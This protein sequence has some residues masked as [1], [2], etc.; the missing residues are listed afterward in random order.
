MPAGRLPSARVMVTALPK[1]AN[2]SGENTLTMRVSLIAVAVL[3]SQP[4]AL[5]PQTATDI[6][7]YEMAGGLSSLA[8][9]KPRPMATAP[10]Y[11]NQPF[12]D[13]GGQR[14]L[15]TANRDGK[16]TDI[17]EF[18][19]ASGRI[20]QLT[21]TGEG[22]YSPT[23]PT[24]RPTAP[25]L[26][27]DGFTVVRV[28]PDGTQRLWQFDRTGENPLLVLADVKPVG[29]HVWIDGD[30]LALYILG[31]PSTLQV[32][33][34]SGGTPEAVARDVGRTLRLVPGSS[35]VTFVQREA[36]GQ[37]AIRSLD[38]SSGR[39]ETITRT[40]EG[41]FDRDY[42]WLPDGRTILMSAGTKVLAWTRGETGWREVLDVARDGL[43][44]VTRMAVSPRAD[45]L[46]VVTTERQP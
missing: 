3:L 6:H 36:E 22:E 43:G 38:P 46:A 40:V 21:R 23:I 13:A 35:L 25:G 15:F 20:Q 12:F 44:A 8:R 27:R 32:A 24:I 28:E 19:R 31:N 9:A 41:S 2:D 26:A 17:Y 30:R 18:D 4:A 10:G 42:E 39:T 11:E 7:L 5:R 37:Y 14:V 16:Q 1:K 29:Y 45:A 34:V 33:R